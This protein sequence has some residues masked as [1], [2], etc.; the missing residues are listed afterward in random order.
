MGMEGPPPHNLSSRSRGEHTPR[1]RLHVEARPTVLRHAYHHPP[2]GGTPGRPRC[3]PKGPSF[4]TLTKAL[5]ASQGLIPGSRTSAPP[6][7]PVAAELGEPVGLWWPRVQLS[8]T[9]GAS[10]HTGWAE[11]KVLRFL[12][13][14]GGQESPAP[15]AISGALSRQV[16]QDD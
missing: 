4:Q 15:T 14:Q 9:Q 12:P 13:G 1:H 3:R 8:V 10:V 6:W 16:E 5:R 2:A 7:S 11:E